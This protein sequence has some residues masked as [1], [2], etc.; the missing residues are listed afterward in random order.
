MSETFIF[1]FISTYENYEKERRGLKTNHVVKCDRIPR[2][3]LSEIDKQIMQ[4]SFSYIRVRRGYSDISFSRTLSDITR[5]E[6]IVI[7]SWRLSD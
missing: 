5:W 1:N 3:W 6:D 7:F 2:K 4:K